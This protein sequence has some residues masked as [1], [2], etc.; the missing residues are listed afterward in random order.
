MPIFFHTDL[1]RMNSGWS[2]NQCL[3]K[4]ASSIN[5]R[6]TTTFTANKNLNLLPILPGF[7]TKKRDL[8]LI[9]FR[10]PSDASSHLRKALEYS[11]FTFISALSFLGHA[12]Y[13]LILPQDLIDQYEA[14][15]THTFL[16]SK[17]IRSQGQMD[18]PRKISPFSDHSCSAA[19][20]LKKLVSRFLLICTKFTLKFGVSLIF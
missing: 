7:F 2:K 19:A 5:E 1:A 4:T 9:L 17:C 15:N 11:A 13:L 16:N 3:P 20:M 12:I 18:S 8:D 14:T 6:R 10:P